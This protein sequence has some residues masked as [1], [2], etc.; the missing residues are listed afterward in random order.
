MLLARRAW[1]LRKIY[2]ES[3][4][5]QGTQKGSFFM[6]LVQHHHLRDSAP[7]NLAG[8][9]RRV[10]PNFRRLLKYKLK[11]YTALCL[12]PSRKEICL[13]NKPL[14][15]NLIWGRCAQQLW[16]HPKAGLFSFSATRPPAQLYR[17]D[18]ECKG[19]YQV[20]YHKCALYPEV[21]LWAGS[22]R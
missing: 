20:S 8:I 4:L 19:I 11:G 1:C 16:H 14:D 2:Y 18:S 5:N 6:Q 15:G 10:I 22:H 12:L 17:K 7:V 13:G 21:R 3:Q 9:L